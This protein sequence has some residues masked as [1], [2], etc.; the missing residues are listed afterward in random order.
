MSTEKK[1]SV[2]RDESQ[3]SRERA[4]S[5]AGTFFATMALLLQLAVLAK[6]GTETQWPIINRTTPLFHEWI[7]GGFALAFLIWGFL[8]LLAAYSDWILNSKLGKAIQNS[9]GAGAIIALAAV[10]IGWIQGIVLA[11]QAGLNEWYVWIILILG[12]IFFIM[13]ALSPMR[14]RQK[15]KKI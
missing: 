4:I 13:Y 10:G 12:L 2:M 11:I 3:F 6:K 5:N 7:Y 9:Y 15:R 14:L 8:V 1:D